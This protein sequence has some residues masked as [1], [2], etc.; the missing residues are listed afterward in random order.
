[1]S[2]S[3]SPATWTVVDVIS[4]AHRAKLPD[5]TINALGVN[6][7]DGPT[8]VTLTQGELRSEL[9]MASLPARRYLWDLIVNL[10]AEQESSDYSVAIQAH[11][12][13]IE[14][15]SWT[16]I[17]DM[18]PD[19]ASGVGVGQSFSAV[20]DELNSDA[21]RQRQVIEDHLMALRMHQALK[22]GQEIYEDAEVARQEQQRLNGLLAQAQEDLA[23]AEG[24]ARTIGER[25]AIAARREREAADQSGPAMV[26]EYPGGGDRLSSLFGLAIRSCATNKI[27]VAEAFK[28]G[29]ITPIVTPTVI[30]DENDDDLDRK[31]A[32]VDLPLAA[33]PYVE[34]CSVC[35][36]DNVRG[37]S[38]AC[39]H[40]YCARCMIKLMRAALKDNS[41]LPLRC[42]EIPIDM[43]ISGN[44][45]KPAEAALILRRVEEIE[46][47]NKMYCPTCSCFFNLDLIDSSTCT[48]LI[49]GC[50]TA[51]CTS[52][53]TTA[54]AGYTCGENQA[55]A[56]GSDDLVLALSRIKGW[57]QCPSCATMIELRSGC[58]HMSCANCR[59]EFCYTCLCQW[60][61]Q[62]G[63]CSS[64]S[65][66][67]WDE[68]RL[69]EAGEARVQQEEAARGAAL[70]REV[71]AARL[72]YAVEGLR[73]NEVC[74]HEWRRSGG[75][76]G[77]CP[78]C[79][80]EMYCY[81]M[82]CIS[83]CEST[84][85]Y[86]CAHHRI[87]QRGWR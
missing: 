40:L 47:T 1:M 70:P 36:E 64:G 16:S 34:K 79:G 20:V 46:A 30:L 35:Y 52:C 7:V 71:R 77:E 57:K 27:N 62:S 61:S 10:K 26:P 78:N 39:G 45:L 76:K 54:H 65:C 3:P 68:G 21:Q 6:H 87:P 25:T 69:L 15:I 19:A 66:E 75:Y 32:A 41:L 33:L 63:Q 59:H 73:A 8:L 50:G 84:V 22:C 29:R 72:R 13:E 74:T 49:C 42:C 31:P 53:K 83:E 85:C 81:G 43:N 28:T 23:Y 24:L 18:G 82:V 14:S 67:L 9:G 80:Y 86:T 4:W 5:A 38:L 44:L 2:V 48:D 55:V 37:Y 12:Q 58:N 60:N 51:I 56:T 17:S 11:E